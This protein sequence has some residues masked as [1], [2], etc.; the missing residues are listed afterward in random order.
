M[1]SVVLCLC[2]VFIND[3]VSELPSGV[4]AALYADDLVLWCN[5]EHASTANYRIQQVIGQL[6]AWTEDWF[7]T[8]NKDKSSTTLFTLS[9]KKQASPIKIATHLGVTFDMEVAYPTHKGKGT[10]EAGNHAQTSRNNM[11]S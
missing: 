2:T 4:K 9:P 6:T 1:Y 5:E 3:L 8:V 7:V 10:Q 11:G